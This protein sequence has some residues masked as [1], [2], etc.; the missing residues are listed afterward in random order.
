[1]N[2]TL[3]FRK[4]ILS[5]KTLQLLQP[6]SFWHGL[7]GQPWDVGQP[8]NGQPWLIEVTETGQSYVIHFECEA[9]QTIFPTPNKGYG[10][11]NPGR[12][13]KLMLPQFSAAAAG[14]DRMTQVLFSYMVGVPGNDT[15]GLIT[16]R[17]P[18][19]VLRSPRDS[20]IP[21]SVA[22]V[23]TQPIVNDGVTR[24]TVSLQI[25]NQL[26]Q[27][28]QLTPSGQA[29]PTTLTVSFDVSDMT[30]DS[31]LTDMANAANIV[32]EPAAGTKWHAVDPTSRLAAI[33]K[34]SFTTDASSM[35]PQESLKIILSEI[36]SATTAQTA[37]IRISYQNL[38]DPKYANGQLVAT[39]QKIPAKLNR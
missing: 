1:V 26:S 18:L 20:Q 25:N 39:V 34:F 16:Q 10:L 35:A 28:L 37:R 15:G 31:A 6:G 4:G 12:S 32:C 24:N 21:F 36:V 22:V 5:A 3:S 2:F 8:L 11:F 17:Q 23:D 19:A 7:N 27:P 30:E 33:P 29:A 9:H 38:P 13:I 14:G